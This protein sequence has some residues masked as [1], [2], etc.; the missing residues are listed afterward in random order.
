ML[1]IP[2]YDVAM[3]VNRCFPLLWVILVFH[4]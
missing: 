1:H 2:G 3:L 4:F